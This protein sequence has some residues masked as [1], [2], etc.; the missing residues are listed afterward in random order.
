M[1]YAKHVDAIW[2]A[3]TTTLPLDLR[4]EAILLARAVGLV[5]VDSVPWSNVFKNEG[6]LAAPALF[7]PA[8]PLATPQMV[9]TA[10]TAHMLAIIGS[11]A[12]DRVLD[13][14]AA[15]GAQMQRL[16]DHIRAARDKSLREL[17]GDPASPYV[18]ADEQVVC[19]INMERLILQ[20]GAAVSLADYSRL[21]LAKQAMAFPAVAALARAAGWSVRRQRAVARTLGA[22]V[23]GL[24]FQ[25]DV[26]DWEDDWQNGGAWAACLARG[27]TRQG[28]DP[29]DSKPDLAQARREVHA[30]GVLATMM[31]MARLH[32][33]AAYRLARHLGVDLVAAW[34]HDQEAKAAELSER[35]NSSAGYAVRAHQLSGWA[36][37][38]FG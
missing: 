16:L 4:A 37:E 30:S 31:N 3:F 1:D 17:S 12:I 19:A 21:S 33:R 25:D 5:P 18:E 22:C 26:V 14:Q 15:G 32:Y 38:V 34:A 11:F 2:S 8:M 29:A 20:S 7:A 28:S 23:L 10:T 6:T 9:M 13:G 27:R 24:Q 36:M 35:E